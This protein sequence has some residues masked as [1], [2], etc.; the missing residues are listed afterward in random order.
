VI[1]DAAENGLKQNEGE[2]EFVANI[3][4]AIEGCLEVLN[5]RARISHP[6]EQ[7]LEVAVG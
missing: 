5:E 4:E 3:Q 7:M 6:D 2:T 1:C